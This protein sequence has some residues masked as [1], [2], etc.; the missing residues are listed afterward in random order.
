MSR[1]A[2]IMDRRIERNE[3]V[4]YDKRWREKKCTHKEIKTPMRYIFERI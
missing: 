3:H 4:A 1:K 2:A